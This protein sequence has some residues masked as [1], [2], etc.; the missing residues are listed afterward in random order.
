MTSHLLKLD[1]SESNPALVTKPRLSN[2][3]S[4]PLTVSC[5]SNASGIRFRLSENIGGVCSM[6]FDSSGAKSFPAL[7]V[8]VFAA[9]LRQSLH[10]LEILR[11]TLRAPVDPRWEDD[12][13]SST[14]SFDSDDEK[15]FLFREDMGFLPLVPSVD[16]KLQR[17]RFSI[18]TRIVP[19]FI[20]FVTYY[21]TRKYFT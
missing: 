19:L 3:A 1:I 6:M 12:I 18:F 20:V 17:N 14:A 13:M 21:L 15:D 4:A 16:A 10:R 5:V 11:D 7:E 2:L 8:A 9:L